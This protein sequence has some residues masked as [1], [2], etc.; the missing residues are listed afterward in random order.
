ML[1]SWCALGNTLIAIHD[2]LFPQPCN[3][4]Q[5]K[6]NR[7]EMFYSILWQVSS[8]EC[9][10]KASKSTMY[11]ASTVL[12]AISVWS[13]LH[14]PMGKQTYLI[15]NLVHDVTFS[16]LLAL[17][18]DHPPAKSALTKHSKPSLGL[19]TIMISLSLFVQKSNDTNKSMFVA[20][21]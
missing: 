16:V 13:L 19:G 7:E 8:K 5:G 20:P 2:W 21:H 1:G 11:S 14:Q 10:L 6:K 17:A 4:N 9:L 18:C 15:K 3:R 12:K